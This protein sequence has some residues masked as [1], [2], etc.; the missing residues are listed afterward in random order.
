MEIVPAAIEDARRNA[1]ING[2]ENAEFYV[3][4]AEEV[5]PDYYARYA[6]ETG[7]ERPRGCDRGGSA[8]EGLRRGPAGDDRENAARAGGVC[9]L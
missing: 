9:E 5:L 3:G 1:R 8:A 6:K 7:R 4:K 2:I